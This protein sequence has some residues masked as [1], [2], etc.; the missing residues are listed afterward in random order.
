[1]KK[2]LIFCLALWGA[3]ISRP[4]EAQWI[5]LPTGAPVT[6]GCSQSATFL[7]R[8][9]GLDATHVAAYQAMICGMV[10][11]GVWCGSKVDALW[12]LATQDSTTAKLNLCST[13]FT[14]TA[15]GAPNFTADAGYLGID[16]ST[17]VYLDTGL[18]PATAGGNFVLNSA[19]LAVW[20]LTNEQSS[21]GGSTAIGSYDGSN[22]LQIT[23]WYSDGNSYLRVNSTGST[24]ISVGNSSGYWVE[25]RSGSGAVQF[26]RNGSSI[27][28]DTTAS[29]AIPS[30]N[31]FVLALNNS[32]SAAN[33]LH[34]R[35]AAGHLG[36]S[37]TSGNVTALN[38][39]ICTFLTT[40]HGSC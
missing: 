39:R 34:L 37:L 21:A 33:G 10:T 5:T 4:V 28:T 38:S 29:S 30:F 12:I 31:V 7:A 26:Y 14:L 22:R 40:V 3:L 11:D 32:G 15:N 18:N 2:G 8:T 16:S 23:P 9:S 19:H 13:S 6:A 1:M 25:N 35:I 36:A 27:G 17:T 24:I 20:S